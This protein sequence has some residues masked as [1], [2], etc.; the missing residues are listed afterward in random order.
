M[1]RRRLASLFCVCVILA[2]SL[3]AQAPSSSDSKLDASKE[4]LVYEHINNLVRFEADGSGIRDS[5]A[6]I[7]V[8]SQAA[9]QELGQLVFGYSSASETLDIDYVRVRKPDGQV[10]ETPVASAQ[11]FAPDILRDAPMYSDYRQRHVSVVNLQPGD[12][13]EYHTVT[14]V[15]P[16]VP[17]EFWYEHKFPDQFVIHDEQL[18]IDVPKARE[19]KLKV[20]PDRKYDVQETGDRRIY[21]WTIKDFMPDRKRDSDD[22]ADES[23]L[24]PDVQLTTF[25]NWTDIAHWYSKLQGERVV[26][27]DSIRKK[28]EE[29]TKGAT[30]PAEKARRLYNYVALNIRYVSLSFGVGRLQPHASDEVLQ[31]GFGDCKDKHT[32]LEA[33]LRAEGIQSYPVLINSY[34]KIDPDVPSP[35]QFDHEITAVRL[36]PDKHSFTWLDTTA[37]VAP[38]GLIEYEL[39]N[40]QAL[41]ASDDD[42][43]GLVRTPADVPVKNVLTL[44]LDGKFTET[45]ALEATIDLTAQGDSDLPLRAALRQVPEAN[46]QRFVEYL[47]NAWGFPG[48]VSDIHLDP[49]EDTSKPFHLNYRLH[50][51]NYFRVPSSGATFQLLPP[52]GHLPAS[53]GGKKSGA[54]PLDVGPAAERTYRAHVEFP[55]NFTVHIPDSTQMTRDYGDYS[56]SYKLTKNVL[57]AERRMVLKVNEL[58][59]QRRADYESFRTVTNSAAEENLWCSITPASAAAVAEAAKAGGTPDEMQRSAVAA[60]GRSDFAT[61]IDLLKRTLDQDAKQKD[62]WDELGRAYAG[63]NQHEQAIAAFRKQIEIDPYHRRANGDLASELQQEGKIDEAIS[64]YRK[65]TEITPSDQ[66]AHKRLGML[67]AQQHRDQEALAELEIAASIPPEDPEVKMALAQAYART[68]NK[69]KADALMKELTGVAQSATGSDLYAAALRDDADPNQ[70]LHD[71]RQTLDDVGDQFDSGAYDKLGPSAY[72]AMNLV[73]LAWARVGWAK[74]LQ[75]DTLGAMQYLNAS[76]LLGQSGTVANRLARVYAKEGQRDTA[77]HMFALAAAAGGNDAPA[78]RQ[79]LIKLAGSAEAVEKAISAAKTELLQMRTVTLPGIAGSGASAQVGLV[80]DNSSKPERAECLS[81]DAS[82]QAVSEKLR[83]QSFQVKFPDV[84]SIKIVRQGTLSCTASACTLVLQPLE[85]LQPQAS[86]P[87]GSAKP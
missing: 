27:D 2:T 49:L 50:A 38:Y 65:Q 44:T 43:A 59:A 26:V 72:S 70:T 75:N 64:T 77:E 71:A 58:P 73:A 6:V 60:L 22:E 34:R 14:H 30:T 45:G 18:Q 86:A 29:L 36:G 87:G 63:L 51:D 42:N 20:N 48:D 69:E 55:A 53:P 54:E 3:F 83:D 40:K 81:A 84:S 28:A 16:L 10:V 35:A 56:V 82:L 80:F 32:L 46:R 23:E 76:W 11:D 57:E 25:T 39:R 4:A 7:R 66:S 85:S 78:S 62:A 1:L 61:A 31:N 37:E 9:I 67:L 21:T 12:V 19:I 24:E 5:T 68:G 17:N 47:S 8:Q 79:E 41:L 15:K 33:L 74:F 13:L 52:V